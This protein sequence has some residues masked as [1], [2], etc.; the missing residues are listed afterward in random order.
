M[1]K[2]AMLSATETAEPPLEPSEDFDG[3][4]AFQTWP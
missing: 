2:A 1:L 4:S 3:S